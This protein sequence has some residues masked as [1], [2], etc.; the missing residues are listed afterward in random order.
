MC[1]ALHN[2]ENRID[3]VKEA[4]SFNA[5][6]DFLLSECE[7]K[8]WPL[9]SRLLHIRH[10]LFVVEFELARRLPEPGGISVTVVYTF[11]YVFPSF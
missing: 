1:A 11:V 7:V 3:N 5:V 6:N 4:D 9:G 10:L 2:A 8:L